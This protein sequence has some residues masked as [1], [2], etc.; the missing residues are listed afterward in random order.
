MPAI[1]SAELRWVE[2]RGTD[3]RDHTAD[4]SDRAENQDRDEKGD[5]VDHQADVASFGMF[6]HGAVEGEPSDGEGYG[7]GEDDAHEATD[8][9]DGEG[10]GKKLK[11]DMAAARAEGFLNTDFASALRNGDEHDVHEPDAAYAQGEG[12]DEGEKDLQAQSDDLELVN[13]LH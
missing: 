7:V 8:E 5:G 11:E 10:F 2:A 9:S 1:R 13:L 4:E 3:G 12:T 6:R